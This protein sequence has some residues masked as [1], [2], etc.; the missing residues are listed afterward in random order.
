MEKQIGERDVSENYSIGI[1]IGG[2]TV[3]IAIIDTTGVILEKWEIPTRLEDS[4]SFIPGDIWKSIEEKKQELNIKHEQLIGIGVGAPGFVETETGYIFQA[5]NIG[6]SDYQLGEILKELSG[7]PVYVENDAN[8]AAIGENWKGSGNRADNMIAI[9]LGTGVGGGIVAAGK[10]L[11]GTNGMAGEIGHITVEPG[12]APCNCGRNGCLETVAS[13]SGI[14]RLAKEYCLEHPDK[15]SEF[16]KLYAKNGKLSSKEVFDLAAA[17]SEEARR[18]VEY[19]ADVLGLAIANMAAVTNPS[20]IV[21]GGGVSKAGDLL[22]EP[23]R[24]AFTKYALKR[25]DEAC[26]F[27]IAEL[28]NDAGVVGGAYLVMKEGNA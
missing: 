15:D 5:V 8:L 10:V 12:G 20:R 1:D 27:V 28:G 16:V 19:V 3:K 23:L 17:G 24:M 7:L 6:W 22:L 21:I 9:T 25:I 13:A 26:E 18:V 11:N 2:T 4:G 14:S